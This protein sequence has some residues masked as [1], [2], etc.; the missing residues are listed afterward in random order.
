MGH[1]WLM[2]SCPTLLQCIRLV[3]TLRSM[4]ARFPCAAASP[5][6]P[7]L[8]VRR[9]LAPQLP[10]LLRPSWGLYS[11]SRNPHSLGKL[12]SQLLTLI[13]RIWHD[14]SWAMLPSYL[15]WLLLYKITPT[16]TFIT[17][18]LYLPVLAG[19]LRTRYQAKCSL[20]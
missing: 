18:L 13:Y 16:F 6:L 7:C 2:L 15:I 10:G 19:F 9:G 11:L 3:A 5:A 1:C 8:L 4:L 14:L 17:V 20:L 12:S